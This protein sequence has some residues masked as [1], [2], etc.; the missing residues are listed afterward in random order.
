MD[1]LPSPPYTDYPIGD[2]DLS[3]PQQR[4]IDDTE[5]GFTWRMG[6]FTILEVG[7]LA[8]AGY[9]STNP[10]PVE[11]PSFISS[12]QAI[13]ATTVVVVTW[14]TLAIIPIKVIISSVFSAECF[15]Q[16]RREGYLEPNRTDRV[17]LATS[18]LVD[19]ISFFWSSQPTSE[20]WLA[21]MLTILVA[22]IGP[23]G[24]AVIS[25]T[26]S[27]VAS[28]L[29][30]RMTNMSVYVPDTNL[31]FFMSR[32][33]KPLIELELLE[34]RVYGYD[35][36]EE[37]VLI[38]WPESGLEQSQN[39]TMYE[40]DVAVYDYSCHWTVV[41]VDYSSGGLG[42]LTLGAAPNDTVEW[43]LWSSLNTIPNALPEGGMSTSSEIFLDNEL[44]LFVQTQ[45]SRSLATFLPDY[46]QSFFRATLPL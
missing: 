44:H 40:S 33:A 41:K 7:F 3:S 32:R 19:Q 12:S 26:E 27:S 13:S 29:G 37:G 8:F 14:R 16:Y 39:I 17:S 9:C 35:T 11:L 30:I 25:L 20:Y 1:G 43:S 36:V 15:V 4:H 31:P 21:F 6:T 18:G 22:F 38:P 45:Y 2:E 5:L 23:L 24:P 42:V 46:L 10:I 28:Q 34:G